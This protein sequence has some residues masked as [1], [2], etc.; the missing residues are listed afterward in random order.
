VL[1]TRQPDYFDGE[2]TTGIITQKND[3]MVAQFNYDNRVYFAE[4]PY[5]FLNHRG[6]KVQVIYETAD[7]SKAK[8]YGVIGY[9]ITFGELA[10]SLFI[11]I[12]L[13][14]VAA[15]ITKNPV[16]QALTE[17]PEAGKKKPRKPK[18]NS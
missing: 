12:A 2:R 9:W 4:V 10:A 1:F 7:L 11:I 6:E 3:Q 5:P 14:W 16:P 8:Q 18:Y 17:K 15:S 13:Y